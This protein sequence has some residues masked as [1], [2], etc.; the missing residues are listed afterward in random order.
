[1]IQITLWEF[2]SI[3]DLTKINIEMRTLTE[4]EKGKLLKL[5]YQKPH[6]VTKTGELLGF[7]R[8][9]ISRTMS[10]FKKHEKA[11][12]NRRISGRISE[13][14][15]RDRRA[16]KRIV[17]R[18]H[19]TTAKWLLSWINVWIVQFLPKVF[20]MSSIK[21]DIMEEPPSGNLCFP[22]STFRRG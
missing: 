6:A 18:K 7:L 13:L 11:F 2:I 5:V 12:S 22:L 21:P 16:L 9:T 14:T 17:G 15:D 4:F 3:V 8:A 10:E 19:R 20:G 1:M